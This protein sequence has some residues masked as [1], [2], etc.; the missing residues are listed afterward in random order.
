LAYLI[1]HAQSIA[2]VSA[3]DD[4]DTALSPL[5]HRQADALAARLGHSPVC[6]VYS[7]PYR[8]CIETAR[9]IAS[10]L[11]LPTLLRTELCEFHQLQGGGGLPQP[12]QPIGQV[13]S[14][15][16]SLAACPDSAEPMAWPSMAESLDELVA[17]MRRFVEFL[18]RRWRGAEDTVIVVSHGSPIARLIEAW[19]TDCRAA[20]PSFRFVIDN[21]ALSAVRLHDGVSSLVCLNDVS[22]LT[23]LPAPES[24]NYRADGSIK[25]I[26]PGS[27]W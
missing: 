18:K 17:R 9:P 14:R 7:S 22:H 4:L 15:F 24:A 12:L 13:L 5:G 25:P 2:N 26:P 27:W 23:A 20:G 3:T 19:L 16:P 10:T 8:R 11:G 21:A 1:R 6:A